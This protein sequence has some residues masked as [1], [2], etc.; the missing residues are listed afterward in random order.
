MDGKKFVIWDQKTLKKHEY[1]KKA[2][3]ETLD[4]G[5]S[6]GR[7]SDAVRAKEWEKVVTRI[8]ELCKENNKQVN[9]LCFSLNIELSSKQSMKM[10]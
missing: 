6:R 7:A 8:N 4:K 9:I 5:F 2:K 3:E 1:F 10:L